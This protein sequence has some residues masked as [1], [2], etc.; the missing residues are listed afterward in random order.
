MVPRG[1]TPWTIL[2]GQELES[3][4]SLWIPHIKVPCCEEFPLAIRAYASDPATWELYINGHEPEKPVEKPPENHTGGPLEE[5]RVP[6]LSSI[7]SVPHPK[8][9]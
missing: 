6:L 2:P 8:K 1:Q 4:F 3:V 5:R 9:V 7:F